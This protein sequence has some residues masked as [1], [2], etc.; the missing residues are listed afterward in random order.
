MRTDVIIHHEH[1]QQTTFAQFVATYWKRQGHGP[2]P[3]QVNGSLAAYVNHGRWIVECPNCSSALV[4]SEQ[5]PRF[6]CVECGSPENRSCWYAVAFPADKAD[7][8][9]AL[10]RRPA[11]DGFRAGTRNWETRETVADLRRENRQRGIEEAG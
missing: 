7:I 8:E 9:E 5:D 2:L 1:W 4:V 10:L 3:K 11:R 6:I